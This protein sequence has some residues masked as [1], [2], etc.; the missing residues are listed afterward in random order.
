M[1]KVNNKDTRY[2]HP[3]DVKFQSIFQSM[4][5]FRKYFYIDLSY[6]EKY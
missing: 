4:S 1:F 3:P 2:D 5:S 6:R